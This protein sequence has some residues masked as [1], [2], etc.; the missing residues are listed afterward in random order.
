[1]PNI[2]SDERYITKYETR[3]L[4]TYLVQ[5]AA[6]RVFDS[7]A[8]VVPLDFSK[9]RYVALMDLK[10]TG[11]GNY[12]RVNQAGYPSG[13]GYAHFEGGA[14]PDGY[15]IGAWQTG[16]ENYELQW[17]RAVQI[18][19]SYSTDEQLDNTILG[20]LSETIVRYHVVPEMD[21]CVFSEIAANA[22]PALGNLVS[23]DITSNEPNDILT[24]F[25]NVF[26]HLYDLGSEESDQ[27]VIVNSTIWSLIQTSP[28]LTRYLT[29]DTEQRRG[30]NLKVYRFNG[31][32]IVKAPANRLYTNPVFPTRIGDPH[33]GPNSKSI[34]FIV[35]DKRCVIP[36]SFIQRSKI[37]GRD[38]NSTFD[39]YLFNYHLYHGVIIPKNK[40]QGLYVSVSNSLSTSSQYQV[41]PA[42]ATGSSQNGYVVT[43][44]ATVP[45][46]LAGNLYW[47]ASPLALGAD[48]PSSSN[49][50]QLNK[51]IIDPTNT[52]AYFVLCDLVTN[53]VI[54]TSQQLTLPKHT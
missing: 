45:A 38:L 47:S 52:Q 25:I 24:T 50:V 51:E 32:E 53:K 26:A 37:F 16:W 4:D 1:M 10:T 30:L 42:L 39:G 13:E 2:V 8:K 28:L 33:P 40:R 6:S 20:N 14:N 17:D 49:L 43:D 9:S 44:Y 3:V 19:L 15:P 27:V 46:G 23:E 18:P 54:A 11:L 22:I 5:D 21:T 41:A 48:A 36:R 7:P 34:N 29:V 31:H 35:A 12:G